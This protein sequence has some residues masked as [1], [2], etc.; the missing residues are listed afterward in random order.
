MVSIYPIQRIFEESLRTDELP[1][2][3]TGMSISQ[4][5]SILTLAAAVAL[6]IFVLRSPK[7]RYSSSHTATA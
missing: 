5:V 6:W 2:F 7:L 3:G 1:I 4:N